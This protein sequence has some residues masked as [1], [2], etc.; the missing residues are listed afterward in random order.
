MEVK[1]PHDLGMKI[2][3]GDLKEGSEYYVKSGKEPY[4][5]VS[6]KTINKENPSMYYVITN[7]AGIYGINP[8][9]ETPF[10]QL[11]KVELGHLSHVKKL[12]S[13]GESPDPESPKSKGG[14][15]ATK[16][17]KRSL[18]LYKAGKSIGFTMR[19]SLKAKGLIPRAN[20]STR[21][22]E[23]YRTKRNGTRRLRA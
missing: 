7:P 11:Y 12:F 4:R 3:V 18:K 17:D 8:N 22:S 5:R 9:E 16:K 10:N 13:V 21:V 1:Y 14:Y 15:R 20:G 23:K 19:A 6:I 2:R